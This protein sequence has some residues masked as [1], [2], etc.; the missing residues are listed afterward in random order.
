MLEV[1]TVSIELPPAG[2]KGTEIPKALR[3]LIKAM[4]GTGNL[5]FRFGAKVQGRPLLKLTTV[6]ART[7]KQREVVL[8]W[9]PDDNR[10]DSWLVVASNA[11]SARHPGWA[12]NLARNPGRVE[13]DIGEGDIPVSVEMLV[14]EEHE[15]VWKRVVETAPGYG[16]YMTKTD[17]KMPIFRLIAKE[18]SA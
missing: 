16:T 10:P 1:W 2:T 15:T 18:P 4:M 8:G 13:V 7:G 12:F 17:R 5:M 9:F 6:G 11:G 14:G 3:P